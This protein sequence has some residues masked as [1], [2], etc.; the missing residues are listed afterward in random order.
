MLDGQYYYLCV[1][2]RTQPVVFFSCNG[3]VMF[4]C[5][6]YCDLIK[7]AKKVF[8]AFKPPSLCYI[9]PLLF[10]LECLE[11]STHETIWA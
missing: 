6:G 4:W 1:Y 7:C 8:F 5:W 3:F 11:H 9:R 10:L 2:E